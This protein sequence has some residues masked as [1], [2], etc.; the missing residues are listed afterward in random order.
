[1][2]NSSKIHHYKSLI[3]YAMRQEEDDNMDANKEDKEER[4]K[5]FYHTRHRT[6]NI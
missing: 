6:L 4:E 1:M 5:I 2:T 3:K